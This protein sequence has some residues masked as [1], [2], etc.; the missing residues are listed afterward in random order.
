MAAVP[1][2]QLLKRINHPAIN[3]SYLAEALYGSRESKNR[4]KLSEK[5]NGKKGWK[6]WE[7]EKLQMILSSIGQELQDQ[8]L[9][10]FPLTEAE[11]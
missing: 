5:I 4:A 7:L 3:H 1:D 2:A 10:L 11:K 8:Q 6:E 9:S